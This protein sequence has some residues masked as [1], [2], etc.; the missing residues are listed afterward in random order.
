MCEKLCENVWKRVPPYSARRGWD[1]SENLSQHISR[2][3]EKVAEMTPKW[4]PNSMK[5]FK[6]SYQNGISKTERKNVSKNIEKCRTWTPK[7]GPILGHILAIWPLFAVPGKPWEPKWLPR[8]PQESPGPVQA[9]IFTD[10]WWI[11]H[12]FW[13]DF[14]MMFRVMWATCC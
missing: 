9:S 14:V 2:M 10:F 5:I 6:N 11:L 8:P 12:G 7:W 1:C 4:L 3:L 13:V